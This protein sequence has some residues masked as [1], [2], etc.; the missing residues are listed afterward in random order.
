MANN[1]RLKELVQWLSSF[2]SKYDFSVSS[3]TPASADAS[4]R[5]YYRLTGKG[6]SF[7]VMDSPPPMENVRP[8]IF[9]ASLMEKA[10]LNVPKI[11]EKDEER[12]FLLLSDMGTK[13]Y[14]DV[15]DSHNANAL[16]DDATDALILWQKASRPGVLPE[17]N[18]EVLLRELNLFPE[19]YLK[20][21]RGM[22]LT[23]NQ[24]KMLDRTF[25]LIVDK[26]LSQSK[27]FVHRD[28]M[29][30]N[31]MVEEV[32]NPGILDFQDALYGPVSYDLASLCRDAFISW[33]EPVVIDWTIRYWEKA[34]RAGIPVPQDFGQF[35]MDVEWMGLQR[36]LKVLGI[37]ARINYRDGKPKYLADTQRFLGYV[38]TTVHRYDELKP[39]AHFIDSLEQVGKETLYTF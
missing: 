5:A 30:R 28:Y 7:I 35:W 10:G 4:F 34:R 11:Y 38:Q 32:R 21:H 36:H 17:Y 26:V 39:L 14:L 16:M 2:A 29:P 1:S 12:G 22:E 3:M 20:C 19:W 24:Q 37:F 9:I 33:D 15:L 31:L 27:V 18:R 6:G 25:D 23:D 8:F 13:T